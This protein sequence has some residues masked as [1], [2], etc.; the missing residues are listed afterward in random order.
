MLLF[1]IHVSFRKSHWHLQFLISSPYFLDMHLIMGVDYGETFSLNGEGVQGWF[2]G[3]HPWLRPTSQV[4]HRSFSGHENL[5]GN[6][7]RKTNCLFFT[8]IRYLP[9]D[10]AL[11]EFQTI[12]CSWVYW[13]KRSGKGRGA[14]KIMSSSL[15]HF[16]PFFPFSLLSHFYQNLLS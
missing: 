1:I 11:Q 16:R 3:N 6:S 8:L 7:L 4:K 2:L 15:A 14:S 9:M 5:W 10:W 12:F 13:K